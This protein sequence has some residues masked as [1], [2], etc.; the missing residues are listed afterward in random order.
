MNSGF[1]PPAAEKA[2]TLFPQ[3][4]R[5]RAAAFKPGPGT[6]LAARRSDTLT[7]PGAANGAGI[8]SDARPCR[9]IVFTF[10]A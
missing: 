8:L 6:A 5:W 7:L 4:R 10:D 2:K 1:A 9:G 3:P